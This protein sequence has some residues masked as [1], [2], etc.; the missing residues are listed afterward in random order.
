MNQLPLRT[1]YYGKDEPLPEQKALRAGPLSLIFEAADLRYIRLGDHEI[2]RRV[3]V[4]IR[5]RN[6]DTI[7][8]ALS[9]V[10]IESAD[11]SFHITYDVENRGGDIDFFW[12]GTITGDARGTITFTMAGEAR[13]TFLRNRIGFCVLHPMACAGSPCRVEKVDGTVEQGA[14]PKYISPHQPFMDMTVISHEVVPGV[15]AEVRFDGD[16]FEMEDQRNWTDASYKTYCTPLRIP[17]PVEVKAGTKISQSITLT[18][19]G[20]LSDATKGLAH[21][22]GLTFSIDESFAAPIPRIG[23]GVASHGQ[24]L[25]P[26]ELERLRALNLSHLR[27]DLNLTQSDYESALRA[28]T[29]EAKALGVPLE[30]AL[31]LSDAADD[32]LKGLVV[33]LER[34][35]PAVCAWLI[36]HTAEM[37]TSA[38][39]IELARR[40]LSDA[41]PDA[42]IGAGTNAY[43]TELNRERPPVELVDVVCYSMN[44]QVHAFDNSSLVET[45]EAQAVTVD[46]ARQF[47]DGLPIAVTPVTLKARFNPN[48]TGPEPEP[49]P[50]ELPAPVDER[51]MS[52]F[53]AGW[54]VGSLKYL[55]QS[56]LFSVTYYETTG[57]R[58]VMETEG[59][60]ALPEKFRSISGAVFPLY[61]VLADVGEF[62]GGEVLLA[63]SNAPLQVDGIALRKDGM[64]RVVL[65]NLSPESQHVAVGHLSE[66]VRVHHLNETNAQAA[67]HAPEAFRAQAGELLQTTDGTLELHL[68]PYAIARIDSV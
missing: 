54:T 58:G 7:A 11:D 33:A 65:A 17:Y 35:K 68:L 14:F 38:Q 55:A 6:W 42:K 40:Y 21:G 26:Q 2:L 64:T 66:R 29:D 16:I 37:S 43:F 1:L 31:T 52:L 67:M 46:S 18:L 51:Q 63:R 10:Q 59:G 44:P 19:K 8:P 41:T 53:G 36:F 20:E 23:L 60:S 3:Y 22:A 34:I 9:N 56:S 30:I 27:V 62:R 45:L 12:Q 13:A 28:A 61:H 50:G 15:K 5:D 47:A 39:W 4:A 32:E 48:A 25:T 49:A 24:S 57:W